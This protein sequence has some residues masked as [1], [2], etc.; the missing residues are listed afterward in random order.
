VLR[1]TAGRILGEPRSHPTQPA[2]AGLGNAVPLRDLLSHSGAGKRS[3]AFQ[4]ATREIGPL[5][6][7]DRDPNRS[8][9]D[10]PSRRGLSPAISGKA[11]TGDLPYQVSGW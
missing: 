8:G 7:A 9:G 6:E 10:V 5:Q 4:R 1:E 3:S 2:R 11:G